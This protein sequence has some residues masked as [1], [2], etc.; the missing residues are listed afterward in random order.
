MASAW[1]R[2]AGPV[3]CGVLAA[4]VAGCSDTPREIVEAKPVQTET[5]DPVP[6]LSPVKPPEKTDPAARA[7]VDAAVAA[8]TGGKPAALNAFKA[9]FTVS[10]TGTVKNQGPSLNPQTWAILA[11]WPDR[12]RVTATL[13]TF[14]VIF[15]RDAA[16]LWQHS[17]IPGSGGL[18]PMDDG[19]AE[20]FRREMTGEWLPVLFPLL[21]PAAVLAVADPLPTGGKRTVGVRVW[22]PHLT[23]VIVYFDAESKLLVRVAY[24]GRENQVPVTKEIIALSHKPFAGVQLPERTVVKGA[25]RELAEWTVTTI[26]PVAVIDP[27]KF[28]EP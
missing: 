1:R 21:D 2:V 9:G 17:N 3:A 12:M 18:K 5:V 20:D 22:H 10:R 25:G 7:V 15:C 6:D 24:A 14:Q 16:F 4:A 11:A 8:H 28:R 13:P 19:P 26:E 27:K 23:D